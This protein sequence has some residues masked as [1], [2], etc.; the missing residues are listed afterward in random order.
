MICSR[1]SIRTARTTNRV[2]RRRYL[3]PPRAAV[4]AACFDAPIFDGYRRHD[5]W[6]RASDWPTLAELNRSL[7]ESRVGN[8]DR[9][10]R[11][12]EQTAALLADGL[13]YEQ[14][15]REH[16]QVP[17]R[18]ENWHD[19]FNA[20]VWIE[21]GAIK[22]ALNMRQMADIAVVGRTQR[23][24]AQCAMT[25]FDEAGAVV[26]LRDAAL[27]SLW[28]AH[29]WH[30]L[31][32]RERDAWLDGRAQALVFGHALLEHALQ[33]QPVHTAKCLVVLHEGA[34][35]E[36][37]S[38]LA[39]ATESVARA[40][41]E[42]AVMNDPQELRPLPLSG[43]PGWHPDTVREGFYRE[44]DYFRPLREGRCYPAPLQMG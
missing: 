20:L 24:R 21:H 26:L 31:F 23:T 32:W 18:P 30:G 42:G 13:H 1:W 29:D 22:A 36:G 34:A 43:I 4:D 11:F 17:T 37:A 16:A 9:S 19:L 8:G 38:G 2:A 12:V 7:A 14:R 33:R 3:A 44:A 35:S 39:Q 6:L 27:L 25:H 41:A 40:I 10:L 28:D 5:A 15:I